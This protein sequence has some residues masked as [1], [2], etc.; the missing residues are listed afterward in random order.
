[1]KKLLP[2]VVALAMLAPA[3]AWTQQKGAIQLKSR[4]EVELT[5]RS[6]KGAQVKK[7]VE[8]AKTPT[9]PGT[10]VIFTTTYTNTGKQPA[11]AV[12]VTNPVPEH[13]VYVDQSAEGKNASIAFSVDKGR[14][15]GAPEKL[16]IR[17]PDRTTRKATAADYT[18]IRWTLTA[19][20]APGGTGSVSFA[21]KIK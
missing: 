19:P 1:M 12:V 2:V 21:A 18:H 7:L 10:T 5:E 11:H 6:E 17:N 16:V 3:A 9:V 15:Y 13:T 20:I 8:L 14:T 4:A